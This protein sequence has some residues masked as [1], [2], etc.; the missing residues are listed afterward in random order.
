MRSS[1]KVSTSR[2]RVTSNSTS[3]TPDSVAARRPW[4]VSE[5]RRSAQQHC[6]ARRL[7]RHDSARPS[8]VGG[9]FL[10]IAVRRLNKCPVRGPRCGR[11]WPVSRSETQACLPVQRA[12]GDHEEVAERISVHDGWPTAGRWKTMWWLW[13]VVLVAVV[14]LLAGAMVL[15]Q[16]RR[17]SGTVIAVNRGRAGRGGG[18]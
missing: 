2:L 17:R 4:T 11:G 6:G 14:A 15:V 5:R 3:G 9:R 7:R 8:Q 10:P 13:L 18:R 16:A 1:P 12:T